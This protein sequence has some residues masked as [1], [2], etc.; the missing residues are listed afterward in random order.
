MGDG[1]VVRDYI[2]VSDVVDAFSKQ[3]PYQ[4]D[5]RIFNISSGQGHSVIEII[6]MI[7]GLLKRRFPIAHAPKV[8]SDVLVNILDN[9]RAKLYLIGPRR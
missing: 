8:A 3:V 4:G 5:E 7:E 9:T 6:N 1:T 2:H